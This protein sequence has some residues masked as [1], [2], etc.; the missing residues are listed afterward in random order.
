MNLKSIDEAI[1]LAGGNGSRLYPLTL[2]KPKPLVSICNYTMLDWN[3]FVLASNGIS[4][5][6]VVVKYLGD[7]IKEH[8]KSFSSKMFP[9]LDIY[10]P[11]VDSRDTA[12]ALRGVSR[13]ITSENFFVTMADIVTNINLKKMALFHLKKHALATISLKRIFYYPKQFGVILIDQSSKVLR[14]LEKPGINELFYSSI[15]FNRYQLVDFRSNLINSGIYC[16]NNEILDILNN[17]GELMDFG[18][19]VFP[20]LI[21]TRK[22]IYGYKSENDYYWQDCGHPNQVLATN[23]DV[24]NKWNVPYLPRGIESN[25]SFFGIKDKYKNVTITNPVAIG[26]EVKINEGTIIKESSI[27]D[28]TTIGKNC[29]IEKSI[30]NESVK[31]GNNV[32]IIDSIISD[33]VIINDGCVIEDESIIPSGYVIPAHSI[34]RKGQLLTVYR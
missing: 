2:K 25:G 31:I 5:A 6:T 17:H 22:D 20:Y 8:I 27:N 10:V 14:F 33:H 29:L 12:D 7:Q 23:I 34:I 18:K 16:F 28:N 13:F 32:T 21:K 26:N 3:F 1:I 15:I 19:N 4:K 30:I 11:D 9:N 24:L